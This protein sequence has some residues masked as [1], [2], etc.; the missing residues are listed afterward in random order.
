MES[1]NLFLFIFIFLI[2]TKIL[3]YSEDFGYIL[4]NYTD[5]LSKTSIFVEEN[6]KI[7]CGNSKCNISFNVDFTNFTNFFRIALDYPSKIQTID[8]TNLRIIPKH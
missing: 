5:T 7:K 4:L 3:V 8:L 2:N 6:I 1:K